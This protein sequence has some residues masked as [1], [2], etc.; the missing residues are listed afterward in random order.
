LIDFT[1]IVA[2]D[3]EH[4]EEFRVAWPT[5]VALR[6]EI[7]ERPLLL[8]CDEG[9]ASGWWTQVLDWWKRHLH[10]ILADCRQ[11]QIGSWGNAAE[12]WTQRERALHALVA[13]VQH[14]NTP[15]YLKLDT[16]TIAVKRADWIQG[17]WFADN[18]A[19]VT[20]AW[21]YTKPADAIQTLDDWADAVPGMQDFPRLDLPFDP[22]AKR[23]VHKRIISY[24]FFGNTA[25]TNEM[26]AT[27]N[28]RL[29]VPS[30]DTFLWYCAARTK[31]HYRTVK[32]KKLG[33]R[34]IS[35]LQ[36]MRAA[37]T[38]ALRHHPITGVP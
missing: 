36:D 27:I 15:W 16:D 26:A 20:A 31:R 13:G 2:L 25:W 34:H 11:V 21:S 7:L 28:G 9:A 18:P 23:V 3:A 19:F 17:E 8:L 1:T 33:W 30:Q 32:M 29:P 37:A 35:R 12:P 22:N 14:V 24:V 6:P 38:M 5:W 4:L 10:F